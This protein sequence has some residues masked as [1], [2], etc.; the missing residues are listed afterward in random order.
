MKK[1]RYRPP[2][3]DVINFG[4]YFCFEQSE[5]SDSG[6]FV[7]R[8]THNNFLDNIMKQT[9]N[10]RTQVEQIS[11]LDAML[12]EN[13]QIEQNEIFHC[14]S[15]TRTREPNKVKFVLKKLFLAL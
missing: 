13:I 6:P 7:V 1:K 12:Q 5:M 4:N 9:D 14:A 2:Y 15:T 11:E 10:V 8:N 3:F